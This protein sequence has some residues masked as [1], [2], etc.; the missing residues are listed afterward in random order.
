LEPTSLKIIVP[1]SW[2]DVSVNQY[3]ELR[4]FDLNTVVI[5]NLIEYFEKNDFKNLISINENDF[6]TLIKVLSILLD[7]S[8]D[9]IY[10]MDIDSLKAIITKLY[11][12]KPIKL[13]SEYKND[14]KKFDVGK[15]VDLETIIED[16]FEKN[17]TRFI[18]RMFDEQM[19]LKPITEVYSDAYGYLNWRKKIF[20][21]FSG[22]FEDD[23][24]IITDNENP[25]DFKAQEFNRKWN[26]Y[27]FIYKLAGG[28]ILKME[29]VTEI[30]I[31]QA[32]NYLS[33]EKE[34]SYLK[35]T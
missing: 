12:L 24:E 5:T 28:D 6:K 20:E 32:F 11:W 16:G 33:Y 29:A 2:E 19:N 18:N 3:N 34:R 4:E 30:N 9:V 13:N 7:L 22:L 35:Q 1:T 27:G 14:F 23:E 31:I 15:F 25:A 26:W 21:E 8:E 10:K 17:F